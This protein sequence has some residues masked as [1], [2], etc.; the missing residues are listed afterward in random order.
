MRE[1]GLFFG[2]SA[3]AHSV[4][5][6]PVRKPNGEIAGMLV[7]SLDLGVGGQDIY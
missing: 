4:G 5:R 7:K 2:L 3:C 6:K 1:K